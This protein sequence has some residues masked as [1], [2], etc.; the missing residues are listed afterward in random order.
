MLDTTID[1][2]TRMLIRPLVRNNAITILE[3]VLE[4]ED[5]GNF[6]LEDGTTFIDLE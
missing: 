5:E 4:L 2:L 6:L 1:T 3:G